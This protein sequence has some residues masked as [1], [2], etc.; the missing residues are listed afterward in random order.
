MKQI[1]FTYLFH[2]Y[3]VGIINNRFFYYHATIIITE[4]PMNNINISKKILLYIGKKILSYIIVS[5]NKTNPFSI[6]LFYSQISCR[7]NSAIF[8]MKNLY[9]TILFCILVTDQSRFV[10]AAIIYK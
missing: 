2:I 7:T 4:S 5:I 9:S 8:F 3:Y 6:C 1:L 10:L